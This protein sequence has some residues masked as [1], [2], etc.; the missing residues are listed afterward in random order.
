MKNFKSILEADTYLQPRRNS[1]EA[2]LRLFLREVNYHCPLCG[3]ELQSRKQKN[4]QRK[5]F[6][7]H[8]YILRV[9]QLSNTILLKHR[10]V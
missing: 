5:G 7:L 9:L 4:Y 3:K 1:T 10:S 8:T 6:K 2:E